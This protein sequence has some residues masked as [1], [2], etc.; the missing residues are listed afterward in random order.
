MSVELREIVLPV[1]DITLYEF[2]SGE[3]NYFIYRTI[4]ST[5]LTV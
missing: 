2:I 3:I 5:G 4:H 1:Y